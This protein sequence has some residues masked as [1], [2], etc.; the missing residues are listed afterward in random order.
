[1]T[2][3]DDLFNGFAGVVSSII[4]K[5][6]VEKS[7]H[8]GEVTATCE[9]PESSHT[10]AMYRRIATV[11]DRLFVRIPYAIDFTEDDPYT[12]ADTMRYAV[13]TTGRVKVFTGGDAHAVWTREENNRFRAVHD[14]WAHCVCGCPFGFVGEYNAY[15]EQKRYYPGDTHAV[16]FAEIVGQVGAHDYTG[17]FNYRQRA[18]PAPR[19][20]MDL[21]APFDKD[22]SG[23]SILSPITVT[24]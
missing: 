13:R 17:G 5:E 15:L 1:M 7:M 22:F 12:D 14:V 8:Y 23:R 20:W 9:A 10:I 21:C 3:Y 2:R 16:L 11:T 19:A 4:G 18:F 6:Y 24:T